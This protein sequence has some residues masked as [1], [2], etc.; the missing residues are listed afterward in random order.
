M[1][2]A[3]SFF[4]DQERKNI[5]EAVAEAERRTAGEIVPVVTTSSG[6]YDRSE[7]I[8]GLW[9]AAITLACL[10]WLRL[11]QAGP[12]EWERP[13]VGVSWVG[14]LITIGA[15]VAAFI[16]GAAL[17]SHVGWLRRLFTF[18]SQMQREVQR[19]ALR[20][21]FEHGLRETEERTGI[22]IYLSLFERMVHVT[23][24]RAVAERLADDDWR[25]VRDLIL[26]GIKK[27]NPGEGMVAAIKRCG[28]VLE[29]HFPPRPDDKNELP[30]ELCIM[31]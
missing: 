10:W 19:S 6:D 23:G 29:K 20:A 1:I 2:R 5:S 26:N 14:L 22:L 9:F 17:A 7:D 25:E 8:V 18:R 30:N 28:D 13:V 11:P 15:M 31:D 27:G 16:V 4:S 3:S 24:D 12:G 21:F